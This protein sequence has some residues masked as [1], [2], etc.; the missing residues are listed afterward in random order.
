MKRITILSDNYSL[1]SILF[2]QYLPYPDVVYKFLKFLKVVAGKLS[3]HFKKSF[4]SKRVGTLVPGVVDD[5]H[6]TS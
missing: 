6:I 1:V 4:T 3:I 5:T 2:N